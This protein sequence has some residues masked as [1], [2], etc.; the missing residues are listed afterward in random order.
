MI[1]P[2]KSL[3]FQY[4]WWQEHM[5]HKDIP[6]PMALCFMMFLLLFYIDSILTIIQYFLLR[7]ILIDVFGP[8]LIIVIII[9]ILL[10]R[11]IIYKEKYKKFI[12]DKRYSTLFQGV[13][14]ILFII[15]AFV[16]C[17]ISLICTS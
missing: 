10:Y 14:A 1:N 7:D 8:T 12:Y 15:F 16:S 9:G 6:A 17:Y 2:I 4:Y 11:D 5:G 3:F 13:G